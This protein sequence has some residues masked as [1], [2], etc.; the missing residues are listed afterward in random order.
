MSVE[1]VVITVQGMVIMSVGIKA[2][3]SINKLL[4]KFAFSIEDLNDNIST[5]NVVL[6]DVVEVK[7]SIL[8][9]LRDHE[10]R[11]TKAGL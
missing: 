9:Q 7:L 1:L 11:L 10:E 6:Q 2:F 5:M 4:H 8:Q 3:V